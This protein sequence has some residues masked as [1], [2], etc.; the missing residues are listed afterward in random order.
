LR[1]PDGGTQELWAQGECLRR[2][3]H[4]AVPMLPPEE[5]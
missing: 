1:L 2:V 5:Q 3:M 4:P